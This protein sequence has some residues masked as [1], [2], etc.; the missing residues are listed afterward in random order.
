MSETTTNKT[1]K[2]KHKPS[3]KNVKSKKK[4]PVIKVAKKVVKKVAKKDT[5]KKGKMVKL[6]KKEPKINACDWIYLDNVSSSLLCP[7]AEQIYK[8]NLQTR[9]MTQTDK[10][11]LIIVL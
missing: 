7:K 8:K 6:N 11:K 10:I 1:T 2:P 4:N 3:K 5:D 9:A